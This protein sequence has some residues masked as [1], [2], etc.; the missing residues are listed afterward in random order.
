MNDTT[1]WWD[2]LEVVES[3]GTPFQELES[4]S[5]SIEFD[6]LILL[7]CVSS[8]EDISLDRVINDEVNWAKRV[9]FSWVTSKSLHGISHG[10]EINNGWYTCE[11]L[12]DDSSW[13]EWDV[14]ILF[15]KVYPVK[16]LFNI[17]R[18]DVVF[19]TVSDC[20]L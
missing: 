7:G 17:R 2:N 11:I 15:G 5:V 20:R 16:N 8:T 4:L 1:S 14:N 18:L 12:K 9:D 19:V 3:F 10:C 13:L 6:D